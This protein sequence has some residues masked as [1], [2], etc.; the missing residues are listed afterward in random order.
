MKDTQKKEPIYL[1]QDGYNK[2]LVTLD[3]L[4]KKLNDV[5]RGRK[6]A[7]EA[8]FGDGYDSFEFN[9]VEREGKMIYNEIVSIYDELSRVIIVER[10][11]SSDFVDIG[12]IIRTTLIYSED[13]SEEMLFKLVGGIPYFDNN[14]EIQEISVNSPIGKAIYQ[15]KIGDICSYSV[16]NRDFTIRIDEKLDLS[17]TRR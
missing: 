17:K 13:Y 3:E 15:K 12:D 9:E 5:N 1:D 14:S 11:L 10:Q 2:L 8:G 16:N 7:F 6:A 4:K